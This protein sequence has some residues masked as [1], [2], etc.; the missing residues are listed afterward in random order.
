MILLRAR[1]MERAQR[2][3]IVVSL[4]LLAAVPACKDDSYAV[5]SVLTYSDSLAGV[6]QF[7]VHVGNG[8]AQDVLY[9]PRQASESLVL[10]TVH[11]ITFS[12]EFDTS[13][14]GQTSFE[15]EPLD[16]LQ[17]ALGYG[18]TDASI[19]KE[20]VFKVTVRVVPGAIRPEH[21]IDAGAAG[22]GGGGSLSCDPYSPAS[23]CGAGGTC[24]LLC[25]DSEPAIG[26]CYAAG[27]G[28]PGAAC[29]SNIDCSAGSQC[30]TFSAVGCSVKTCLRFCNH[31]D[32]ACA[33]P[34]AYCNVP[35]D[36]GTTPPFVACSRPCNPTVST[37]SGCATGLACF[38]Y[39]DETTDCACAGLGSQGATCTQNQGCNG[40][41]GC[42]GCAA[43]LS[44]VVPAG[45]SAGGGVCRPICSLATPACATGT[46]CHAFAA[47]TR[48]LYGFCQ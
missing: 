33:E 47:S 21:G 10:D 43:G 45:T 37:N 15:I 2:A 41:T 23:A 25:T 38:V 19:V 32:S 13:R 4:A 36:C 42:A 5:I 24:G 31:D 35:I 11:P 44:C 30:F 40:E 28:K 46:T 17:H 12:V 34:G 18:K 1:R 16:N 14:G 8:A 27:A 48:N 7:R 22:D 6:A 26:M 29:A 3:A 39:A 20:K 9:Y